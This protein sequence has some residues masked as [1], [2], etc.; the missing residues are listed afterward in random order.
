MR[1]SE[2]LADCQPPEAF[3][4]PRCKRCGKELHY[5]AWEDGAEL[6]ANCAEIEEQEAEDGE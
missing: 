6:C 3:F 1:H 4:V 2:S 5:S